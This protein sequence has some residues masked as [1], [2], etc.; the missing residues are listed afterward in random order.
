MRCP[1]CIKQRLLS[2]VEKLSTRS[3]ACHK[4]Y[5]S[6]GTQK[7]VRNRVVSNFRCSNGHS[8]TNETNEGSIRI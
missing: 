2:T 7:A 3:V 6:E 8:W 4:Y 5:D 1:N